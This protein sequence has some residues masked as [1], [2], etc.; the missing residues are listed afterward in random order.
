MKAWR[1]VAFALAISWMAMGCGGGGS[2]PKRTD[3]YCA[4]AAPNTATMCAWF[5][6]DA[7]GTMNCDGG[8]VEVES[9]PADGV[10]GTCALDDVLLHLLVSVYDPDV[11]GARRDLGFHTLTLARRSLL[12]LVIP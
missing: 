4:P 11:P 8:S 3:L 7:P 12:T 2:E 9:C 1:L 5:H 10:L 6:S